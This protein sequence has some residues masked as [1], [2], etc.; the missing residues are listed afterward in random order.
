[1]KEIPK[2][3]FQISNKFQYSNSKFETERELQAG[4][5]SLSFPRLQLEGWNLECICYLVLG[6]LNL[7][8]NIIPREV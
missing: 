2:H 8:F 7:E 4:K 3:K 1:L 6:A 5:L